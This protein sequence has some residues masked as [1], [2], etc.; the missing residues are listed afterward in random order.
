MDFPFSLK[1]HRL[2]HGEFIGGVYCP[3]GNRVQNL[4]TVQATTCVGQAW[5]TLDLDIPRVLVVVT[6]AP[7]ASVAGEATSA[8]APGA[9]HSAGFLTRDPTP[10]LCLIFSSTVVSHGLDAPAGDDCG[11]ALCSC[12]SSS[13]N[14]EADGPSSPCWARLSK[15]VHFAG[16]LLDFS[17]AGA[18]RTPSANSAEAQRVASGGL[19]VGQ[20]SRD[21]AGAGPAAFPCQP[22]D[23]KTKKKKKKSLICS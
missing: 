10:F 8:G 6:W 5:A 1:G 15:P 17:W 22:K 2:S 20:V 18:L 3:R 16:C 19:G 11:F 21:G 4:L 13:R 9:V 14:Q 7:G 23:V 12:L